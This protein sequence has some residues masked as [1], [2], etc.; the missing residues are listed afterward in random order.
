M[1]KKTRRKKKFL[2][3]FE[4]QIA[5]NLIPIKN[6]KEFIECDEKLLRNLFIDNFVFSENVIDVI[7]INIQRL[8]MK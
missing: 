6:G 1:T 2:D 5:L 3:P 8:K 4:L 7:I